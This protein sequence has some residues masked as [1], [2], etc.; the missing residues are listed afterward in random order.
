[1]FG[2]FTTTKSTRH[3]VRAHRNLDSLFLTLYYQPTHYTLFDSHTAKS[4]RTI[5]GR[6]RSNRSSH[7]GDRGVRSRSGPQAASGNVYATLS[8]V[9]GEGQ[10]ILLQL[11]LNELASSRAKDCSP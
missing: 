1:M 9:Q 11:I 3:S 8:D 2:H 4:Y 7:A 5:M 10:S 6:K